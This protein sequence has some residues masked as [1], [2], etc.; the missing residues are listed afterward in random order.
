MRK[1]FLLGLLML[2][3][4]ALVSA[5]SVVQLG[6]ATYASTPPAYKS[7]TDK[8]GGYQAGYMMSREIFVDEKENTPIPTND[9]WTDII[10]NRY[11]GSIWSYPAMLRTGDYGVEVCYPSYWADEGKEIKSRS[12]IKVSAPSFSP[13]AT[14]A[15]NWH[16]LDVSFRMPH[17]G[18][19]DRELTVTAAHGI[20]FTWFEFSSLIPQL[21]FI[22]QGGEEPRFFGKSDYLGRCG[23]AIGEDLYG[24]YFPSGRF[25]KEKERD[26]VIEDA[27]W[28][29]VA[30]L[31]KESDLEEYAPYAEGVVRDSKVEWRYDEKSGKVYTEWTIDSRSLRRNDGFKSPVMLGMLPHTYKYTS[32]PIVL[33]NGISYMTPR[34]EMKMFT[35]DSG[36]FSFDYQFSGMMP[37]YAFPAESK[38]TPDGFSSEI[39]T[40]LMQRYANGGGFGGDTY[41]GGKGLVQMALNMTFAKEASNT[42]LYELSKKKLRAALVN[43]LTY[44]PGEDSMFFSYYPRWGAMLGFNVSYDSDAFNDHHFHYGYFTYAAALLCMEDPE[45]AGNYGELLKLIAKDYAN[46]DR[47]DTRFPF[48]RTLDPWCG[49]SWAGGLGD[50]GNDNGNGQESTSEAM[51]SWGGMYLLGVALGDKEMRDAGIWGWCTEARATRE[52]WF[53]VDSPRPANEGGR[54]AWNGKGERKGNYD[55]SQ[56]K[57]AYNSNITGK[58]IGWWTWFGGDPL[59]MH[60]I[61]WMPVSP[62]LDY[63]SWDSDFVDWAYTDMMNGANSTFSHKWFD[64]TF[65]SDNG[66][67]IQPLADNDWGNVTLAY[68]QRSRPQEAAE[69][70]GRALREN[71]HIATAVSTGHISYYLIHHHLTYGDIDFSIHADIPTASA[72]HK[73]GSYTYMVYNHEDKDRTVNFYNHGAIVR[74]VKAPARKLTAFTDEAV[75][76]KLLVESEDGKILP[77]GF[78]GKLNVKV[79]DQYGASYE[80]SDPVNFVVK[81]VSLLTVDGDGTIKISKNAPKGEEVIIN[82][83]AGKLSADLTILVNDFPKINT[84]V[85]K[86]VPEYLEKGST[87][88]PELHIADNYGN[89]AV[90]N[91]VVWSL[92]SPDFEVRDKTSLTPDIPGRYILQGMVKERGEEICTQTDLVLLPLLPEVS[93]K[94]RAYSSSEENVGSKTESVN[95]GSA[96]TRWGSAHTENE[97]I[98]IDLGEDTYLSNAAILWEA[99]YASDYD[100]QVAPDGVEMTTYE[101]VYAGAKKSIRVPLESS[102][103][104]VAEVR[105]NSHAG[106]VE[107]TLDAKGRYVRMKGL[108]RGSVY[109]YSIYEMT[110]RGLPLSTADNVP[111]G[112]DFALPEVMDEGE[113]VTLSPMAY[114]RKGVGSEVQVEWKADKTA[115]FRGNDFIPREEGLMK[116]T[117]TTHSGLS[118]VMNVF[119]NEGIHLN[120]LAFSPST[121]TA[122]EGEE[123]ELV[124]SGQNQFGGNYPIEDMELNVRISDIYANEEVGT[125]VAFYDVQ[126][127]RFK[128]TRK[129]T[130]KISINDGIGL[131]IVKVVDLTEANLAL[132]KPAVSSASY[133]ANVAS[134]VNDG[135]M[136]TRWESPQKDKQWIKIDLQ[137][138]YILD[139][140]VLN[141]EGAYASDYD[142]QISIEGDKWWTVARNEKGK[143]GT[144]TVSLPAAPANWVRLN[145]NRRATAYGNSLYE[146]EVYG[147]ARFDSDVD[148]EPPAS[149][150]ILVSPGNGKVTVECS[151]A[152][153]SGYVFTN[154]ILRNESG[155]DVD[156]RSAVSKSGEKVRIEFDNLMHEQR[157]EVAAE[158]VDVYGNMSEVSEYFLS[159]LDITGKNIAL[160]KD[161]T[162]TSYENA[163]LDGPKALDGDKSTRWGSKFNDDEQITVD[164]GNSYSLTQ[165]RIFWDETA[166]ATD[167][168]V[169]GSEDGN[170]WSSIF[171]RKAWNGEKTGDGCRLDLYDIPVKTYARYVRVTG[172]KRSTQYGTSIRELE[173]YAENDFSH[174]MSGLNCAG[175]GKRDAEEEIFNLHGIRIGTLRDVNL[176][177]LPKGIYIING[178]KVHL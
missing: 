23:V 56:Y 148:H 67:E 89:A 98:F 32:T 90:R 76:A 46:Y 54:L 55:F 149:G 136:Q 113:K 94:G 20:P 38:E 1:N 81:D 15:K 25:L 108:K 84:A 152:D 71:R 35:A 63:L 91:D 13:S 109:G 134:A 95:D 162:V 151:P 169:E 147:K 33:S 10:N 3:S 129:G 127:G 49:H 45:F 118:G 11:S 177:L 99:A 4:P 7:K 106:L 126:S 16:D 88:T 8:H 171:S 121:L 163:S 116:I 161:V 41:W 146:I 114:T 30:L 130:F 145:C 155:R 86:G 103:Q 107:T 175:I 17:K 96:S 12:S 37:S 9:W 131:A 157:Y 153:G 44:T 26:Y 104:T 178:R 59:Y 34:G 69:V 160:G 120:S 77:P 133:G 137:K 173:V 70:F 138:T 43:W 60:G 61:Q 128:A 48:L 39:M 112:I 21:S 132:G 53:D 68:M 80:G 142:V 154:I 135:N 83:S 47:R 158:F 6:K 36:K 111:I 167:Y 62:A 119:V 101:G 42:E 168:S 82:I 92:T 19:G 75:P 14:I 143:G 52:Y 156:S 125:E 100:L 18:D 165:I 87:F 74:T 64:P 174:S 5:Q 31:T 117:A 22:S 110:L 97:W 79:L 122:I 29:V 144:E 51:Q 66:G 150:E 93:L 2:W 115:E 172:E 140:I 27:D 78:E 159:Y 105:G 170:T 166:Y 141:W 24:L 57:Y 73:N 50:A 40:S 124:L 176:R 123:A 58:G 164:L 102:W 72:Y 139:R 65:N 28:L 85:I